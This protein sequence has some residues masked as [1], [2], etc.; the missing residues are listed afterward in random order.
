MKALLIFFPLQRGRKKIPS[1]YTNR[2][3]DSESKCISAFSLSIPNVVYEY[4]HL[5][6]KRHADARCE[7][8]VPDN[9][10]GVRLRCHVARNPHK[11]YPDKE[12]ERPL[13]R[14]EQLADFPRINRHTGHS[15]T[16]NRIHLINYS[17]IIIL[18]FSSLL[19]HGGTECDHILRKSVV[20]TCMKKYPEGGNMQGI[21]IPAICAN[22]TLMIV[23]MKT[24]VDGIS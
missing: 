16:L 6:N 17:T 2:E 7:H 5:P 14:I 3:E 11:E 9:K 8:I 22:D 1:P 12:S 15:G 4:D 20:R 13:G 24:K 10:E 18:I 21:S 23:G 19:S